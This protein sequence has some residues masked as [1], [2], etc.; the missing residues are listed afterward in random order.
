V[1][2]LIPRLA[3]AARRISSIAVGLLLFSLTASAQTTSPPTDWLE[4]N[5][6]PGSSGAWSYGDEGFSVYG[7]GTDIWGTADSFHYVYE[8]LNGDGD[9][10]AKV[11]VVEGEDPWTKVGLMIR[12]SLDPGSPHHFLLASKGKGLAY[13]RRLT[14][15]GTSLNTTVTGAVP[16]WLRIRRAGTLVELAT[17]TDSV[18]WDRVKTV[19]WPTGPTLIGFAV[20]SHDSTTAANVFGVFDGVALTGNARSSPFVNVTNPEAGDAVQTTSPLTIQWQAA[21]TDADA[22]DHFDAYVGFDHDGIVSYQ[23]I[24]E[25]AHLPATA[26]SC[27]WSHPGPVSDVANIL[28]VATDHLNDEGADA[29]GRFTI[30]SPQN[31]S[32]PAGW[33]DQDIGHV[34]A[35]GSAGFD[36]R[37]FVVNGSGADIWGT[38][39]AFNFAHR[40]MSGDFTIT[41]RV[42]SVANVNAWTKAGLMI[43]EGIGDNAR[44]GS[45][46]A[47]PTTIKGT[48][49]QYRQ[50]DGGVSASVAGPA[51]GPP[52]WLKLVR[53]GQTI[54]SYYRHQITDPWKALHYQVYDTPLADTLEVGLA[55]SSHVDGKLAMANFTDVLVEPLPPWQIGGIASDGSASMD[56]TIFGLFGKGSDIWGVADSLK[57]GFVKWVGNGTMTARVT[58]LQNSNAWAKA[59]VMFRESLAP[60][61]KHVFALVSPGHGAALQYRATTDGQSASAANASGTAPAWIRMTRTGN[62]FSAEISTDG[63]TWRSI[64]SATVFMGD[65]VYVGIAHTSHNVSDSGGAIFD[66][67]RIT[68]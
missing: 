3:T 14:A 59:G 41:A 20:T 16:I 57:Y 2:F 56:Q 26:R 17:S 45:F 8:Q 32:L 62:S 44:H 67:L 30:E 19:T 53:R 36:G 9:L 55:V 34:S 1:S 54:T 31:G 48:A 38:A 52:V 5:I 65:S 10:R 58:S 27:V 60:G 35:A 28:V 50:T 64:G 66:D 23:A 61:S 68:P 29:S 46:F 15:G 4:A 12:Q 21:S 6:G 22:L 63:E 51:F 33:S 43:R 49:F 42:T 37:N 24:A 7:H 13:Q 47:T 18:N 40:S 39:D 25:C 11:R